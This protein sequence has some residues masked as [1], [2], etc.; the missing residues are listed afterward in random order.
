MNN[1]EFVKNTVLNSSFFTI[2]YSLKNTL[3]SKET[4]VFLTM[5]EDTGFEPA[6]ALTSTVFKTAALNRSANP[7]HRK[8]FELQYILYIFLRFLQVFLKKE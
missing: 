8:F 7:P 4:N 2:H 5:A 6:E 3:G 1:E